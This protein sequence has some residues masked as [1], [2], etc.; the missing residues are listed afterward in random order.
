M[1]S[2]RGGFLIEIMIAVAIIA[3]SLL[4]IYGGVSNE[5]IRA[6]NTNRRRIAKNLAQSKLSEVLL[7]EQS[8]SSGEFEDYNGYSWD[9]EE[10]AVEIGVLQAIQ[11]RLKVSFPLEDENGEEQ[12]EELELLSYREPE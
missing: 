10:Q 12:T 3:T 2:R 6:A 7:G 9:L 11:I 1:R 4:A 8:G 5:M